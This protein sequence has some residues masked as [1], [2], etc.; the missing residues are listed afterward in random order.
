[1]VN[2]RAFATFRNWGG[3]FVCRP[4]SRDAPDSVAGIQQVVREAARAGRTVRPV[5]SGYSYTRLVQTDEIMLSLENWAGV[6]AIDEANQV[7]VVRGGTPLHQL[8]REL[9]ARGFAM[10]NLGDINRQTIAGAIATGTHGTGITLGNIST[11]IAALE[12]V[13]SDGSVRK[14]TK[15]DG[16]LFRAALV[17]LGALGVIVRVWLQ[18]LP[19]Y[20]LAIERRRETFSS[21]L[22]EM[23]SRVRAN[24]NFEFFWFPDSELVYSKTMNPVAGG[25]SRRAGAGIG[26]LVSDLVNENLAMWLVCT[27]N[28]ARPAWRGRLIDLG[29]GIVPQGSSVMRAD[30]AYATA[31]L[32]VHQ[33]MEYAVP[34]D[35]AADVLT[36]LHARLRRFQTRTLFPIEVRFT[37]GDDL[38]LSPSFGR[39]VA[40]IAVHTW[41]KEDHEEYFAA[42]EPIFLDAGGR[43]HWGKLHTLAAEDL[44]Q[45]YPEAGAFERARRELDPEGR[46]LNGYLRQILPGVC[47]PTARSTTL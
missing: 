17:S 2:R 23:A 13:V 7:A 12:V 20:W 33:E 25:G 15:E 41:W 45:I 32:V 39:D 4:E 34:A 18:V 37:R 42:V 3:N 14:L 6:E 46:F 22:P 30:A 44:A 26:R 40:W 27:L 29:S 36:K 38:C 1:M 5:G 28:H 21:L 19:I 16:E 35:R 9:A 31:R 47:N 8:E 43:P 11:R 24:R 10:E